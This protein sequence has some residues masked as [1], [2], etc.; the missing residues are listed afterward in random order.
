M[1]VKDLLSQD[2]IDA[3]LHG[4]DDGDVDTS[5]DDS[6]AEDL[7]EGVE[8]Y[9]LANQDRI[10]RARMPTL[11]MINERFARASRTSFFNL[12]RKGIDVTVDGIQVM[13]YSDYLSTLY[14]PTSMNLMTMA[15]LKGTAL[16]IFDAKMVYR[17]VDQF[18]GGD[19]RHA[20]I[21]GREFTGTEM[22]I[23][24]RIIEEAFKDLADAWRTVHPLKFELVGSEMNPA[25]ANVVTGNDIVVVSSFQIDMEGGTGEMQVVIPYAMFEPIKGIIHSGMVDQKRSK[26]DIWHQTIKRDLGMARVS[27]N[28]KVLERELTLRDVMQ[29]SAG[30]VIPV[31]MPEYTALEINAVPIYNCQ[32]GQS[33]GNL[34][35]KING[36]INA[37]ELK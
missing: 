22:R 21:E 13:K 30:D 26:D 1:S 18:F 19:G 7:G 27:I 23:V 29:L 12:L 36:R 31:E 16:L 4:V 8:R 32:L 2:E 37:A 25:M 15:P 24:N 28:L 3:L 11:E 35:V 17:V 20:K 5:D 34:A 9:D 10:V 14:V 6:G 33:H